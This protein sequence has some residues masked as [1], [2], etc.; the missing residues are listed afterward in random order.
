MRLQLKEMQ[1]KIFYLLVEHVYISMHVYTYS[2]I[3][4]L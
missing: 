1:F 4:I 3:Y 2:D